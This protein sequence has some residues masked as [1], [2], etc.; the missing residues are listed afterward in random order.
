MGL[1]A[2][3]SLKCAGLGASQGTGRELMEG[4]GRVE[5]SPQNGGWVLAQRFLMESHLRQ[6]C[7][8]LSGQRGALVGL[9]AGKPDPPSWSA[10]GPLLCEEHL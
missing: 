5:L 1:P 8:L 2:A 10:A 7:H 9:R 3:G 4:L 6:W